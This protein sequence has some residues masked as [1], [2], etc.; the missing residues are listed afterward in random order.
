VLDNP[1]DELAALEAFL[2]SLTD[3]RVRFRQAPF[4]HPQLFVPDGHAGDEHA[5]A[6]DG[7][8]TARDRMTEIPAVGRDG[9]APLPG[10]LD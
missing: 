9:G 3:E 5:V 1:D 7:T 2:R 8:G 10:F 6:D 4:D